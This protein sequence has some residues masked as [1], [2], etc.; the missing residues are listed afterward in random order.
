M[1]PVTG[2]FIT[3]A[4]TSNVTV[5]R[6]EHVTFTAGQDCVGPP[7][8]PVATLSDIAMLAVGAIIVLTGLAMLS[9]E[10]LSRVVDGDL[11]RRRFS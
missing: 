4:L 11:I 7:R 9:L 10:I 1:D 2:S 3:D 5:Q 8:A 6:W